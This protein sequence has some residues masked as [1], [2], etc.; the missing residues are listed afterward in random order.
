MSNLWEL[1]SFHELPPTVEQLGS[2][3]VGDLDGDGRV[4]VVVGGEGALLWYRPDTHELG[5]IAEGHFHVGLA[6]EDLDGDGKLE[7]VAGRMNPSTR[8]WT[9]VWFKAGADLSSKVNIAPPDGGGGGNNENWDF[10]VDSFFDITYEIE[11]DPSG[12]NSAARG[13]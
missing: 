2:L 3:A 11:S 12:D 13:E 6:L 10:Q 5:T 7:V 8:T 9:I 4:E 1:Q